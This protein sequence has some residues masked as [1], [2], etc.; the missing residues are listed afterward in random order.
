MLL[1][2][3][4]GLMTNRNSFQILVPKNLMTGKH[5]SPSDAN[6]ICFLLAF[7]SP[8]C[9]TGRR[10]LS[11]SYLLCSNPRRNEDM[12]GEW[13]AP[14]I[15]NPACRIGCGEWRPPMIDN[16][17]YKGVWRPPMIDNPNYQ[18]TTP[19]SHLSVASTVLHSFRYM[20]SY[21]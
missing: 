19:R 21:R 12:D 11:L 13:E 8:V 2:P 4:A 14:R 16:P 1:N 7:L 17:K 20:S 15:S 10:D 3:M 18:V 6:F 5:P 9:M